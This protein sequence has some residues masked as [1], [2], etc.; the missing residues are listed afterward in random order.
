MNNDYLMNDL[1]VDAKA[2]VNAKA[3][4]RRF[5]LFVALA[6]AMFG[7]SAQADWWLSGDA[8]GDRTSGYQFGYSTVT[9][10]DGSGASVEGLALTSVKN[11][12]TGDSID[13]TSFEVDTGKK[14]IQMSGIAWGDTKYINLRT[15]IA[16]DLLK[17]GQEVFS[18]SKV[19]TVSFPKVVT[20][21]SK[22][23]QTCTNLVGDLSFP[24]LTTA[25]DYAFKDNRLITAFS[26]PKLKQVSREM[27][28]GDLELTTVEVGELCWSNIVKSAY[29]GCPKLEKITPEP[30]ITYFN[31]SDWEG[32]I[33]SANNTAYFAKN[34]LRITGDKMTAITANL[35]NTYS[36]LKKVVI[37]C[38]KLATLGGSAFS[39][40]A[41]GAEIVWDGK[42]PTSIG[43]SV[44]GGNNGANN[45]RKKIILKDGKGVDDW[46]KLSNYKALSEADMA[47][48]DYATARKSG[49]VIGV[50]NG[51]TWL[52]DGRGGFCIRIQ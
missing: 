52:I 7:A 1:S 20:M 9:L 13:L 45:I 30:H 25:G 3:T 16:P 12:G 2:T 46:K 35:C 43:S 4:A 47:R 38:D 33:F 27:F 8:L 36:C 40:I 39:S 29:S 24:E 10:T 34:P 50:I 28:M 14:V 5:T 41:D 32:W 17:I 37:T 21:E 31:N 23:F 42:A 6:A 11:V 15:F 18:G 48:A 19:R 26:A 22:A 44:F 49:K 51:T